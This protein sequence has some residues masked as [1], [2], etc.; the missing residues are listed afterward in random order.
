MPPIE[1]WIRMYSSRSR[2]I[3]FRAAE[4]LL[5]RAGEVPLD[6]LMDILLTH[7]EEGLRVHIDK[8]LLKCRDPQLVPRMI[9]LL[10][11]LNRDDRAIACSVL[12]RAGDKAAT[13]HLLR[14]VDGDPDMVVRREAGFAL[15][16]L[17]DGSGL[18]ELRAIYEHHKRDE[19]AVVMAIEWH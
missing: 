18:S 3:R 9:A 6:L 10:G 5:R 12:G 11:S 16:F 15:A 1:D 7:F 8:A 19:Y 17:N 4:G 13:K 2:R 14:M